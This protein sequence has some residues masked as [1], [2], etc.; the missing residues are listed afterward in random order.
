MSLFIHLAYN[1]VGRADRQW[2][3]AA[4]LL[5]SL[6]FP[7]VPTGAKLTNTDQIPL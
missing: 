5:E 6:A 3:Q 1:R 4:S 7:P 2:C